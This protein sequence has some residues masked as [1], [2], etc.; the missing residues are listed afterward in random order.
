[1]AVVDLMD[2]VAQRKAHIEENCCDVRAEEIYFSGESWIWCLLTIRDD[3]SGE[4]LEYDF[5]ETEDSWKRPD[6]VLE[7]NEAAYEQV[8]VVVI[9]PDSSFEE[10][11]ELVTRAGYLGIFISDYSAMALAPRVLVS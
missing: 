2:I 9:V 6:A 7:Y 11:V 4:A 8:E 10:T 3:A 5:I 1:M